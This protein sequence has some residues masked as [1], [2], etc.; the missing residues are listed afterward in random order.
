MDPTFIPNNFEDLSLIDNGF[1]LN[2]IGI[3]D[4]I[5]IP[6]SDDEQCI[7][8]S[9]NERLGLISSNSGYLVVASLEQI[10]NYNPYFLEGKI[11]A[12]NSVIIRDFKG[13][14]SFK[15]KKVLK[16][17]GLTDYSVLITGKGNFTFTTNYNQLIKQ[18]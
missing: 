14:V 18:K 10:K 16:L 6:Y 13:V 2:N 1:K 5:C 11:N 8:T 3:K 9:K 12:F 7:Y 4:F 15:R 17:N